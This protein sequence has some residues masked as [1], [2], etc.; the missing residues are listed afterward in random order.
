VFSPP[1]L[2]FENT[3]MGR[4]VVENLSTTAVSFEATFS[5]D[6]TRNEENAIDRVVLMRSG[7]ITHHWDNDQ[8]YIELSF[9][10]ESTSISSPDAT[11][12]LTVT[13][14]EDTVCAPGWYMLFAIESD[15]TGVI[16]HRVP[17]VA[18]F[19]GSPGCLV[20]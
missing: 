13:A 14:P 3:E 15:G 8:K 11:D 7:A 16:G 2:D 18:Q 4:P 6:V 10:K 12:T 1:Y 20:G 19:L 5:F 17:S 9:I